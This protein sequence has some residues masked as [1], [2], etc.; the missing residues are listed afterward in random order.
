[1]TESKDKSIKA[2]VAGCRNGDEKDWSELMER[3][4][5]VIFS[6]SYRFRLS[7]EESFD[8]FGKV[9]LLLLEN[10]PNLRDSDRIFGYVSTIA[11]HEATAIKAKSNLLRL[12]LSE[13]MQDK[14]MTVQ[15]TDAF[16]NFEIENDLKI[17]ARAFAGISRKCQTLLRMLFV[18]NEE[19]SYQAISQ[20][21]GMPVSSIGPTRGRCLEKLKRKMIEEGFEE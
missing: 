8:V 1:M 15:N 7:R 14:Y 10:L 4:A 16:F 5:P 6:V 19:A 3:L 18:D 21:M 17:M 20:R 2:L 13:Q 9:S 12:K 11:Y